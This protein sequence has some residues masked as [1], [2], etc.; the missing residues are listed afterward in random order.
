M[1]SAAQ[2]RRQMKRAEARGESYTP[3]VSSSSSQ[4]NDSTQSR[5]GLSRQDPSSPPSD[6]LNKSVS[7]KKRKISIQNGKMNLESTVKDLN[8]I[9]LH[10]YEKMTQSLNEAS[11]DTTLDART[12]RSAKRKAE[13]IAVQESGC[14][15]SSELIEW[16]EQYK[17]SQVA[18]TTKATE[19]VTKKNPYILFIGQLSFHT[20]SD[21]IFQ[22]IQKSMGDKKITPDTLKIRL[23]TQDGK[24]KGMA[25][26]EF[27]DPEHM[28]EALKLH[29][30]QLDGRRINVERSV[31]GRKN[32]EVRKSKLKERR[33]EQED[34]VTSTINKI[35]DE[36]CERGELQQDELDDG[37]KALCY[38][39]SPAIVEAALQEYV[40]ARGTSLDNPSAYL[41][42][43][44]C[45][46]T[47]EGIDEIHNK[48][49]TSSMISKGS[50]KPRVQ[51]RRRMI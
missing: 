8:S 1:K 38:R 47:D 32:S 37:V 27:T 48:E 16:Y 21:G 17:A 41:S 34:Y 49:K 36:Y 13:A 14:S 10:A 45:R 28:Y 42:R 7:I 3:K 2:I 29:H 6:V 43:I 40:E 18:T 9:K 15:S 23:L 51:K 22:H 39:R 5:G 31:G 50:Q 11:T 20:T 4:K 44:I 24:S 12:R 26:A 30:T 25:F 46:I 33:K 35:I 19:D